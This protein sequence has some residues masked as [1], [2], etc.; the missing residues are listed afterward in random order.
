MKWRATYAGPYLWERKGC[1]GRISKLIISENEQ[2]KKV[3]M[4]AYVTEE[5]KAWLVA[6]A[7]HL[8]F[9]LLFEG[10]TAFSRCRSHVFLL[11]RHLPP[12]LTPPSSLLPPP[13]SL[14]PPL[15]PSLTPPFSS[16]LRT[17]RFSSEMA[18]CDAASSVCL[19]LARGQDQRDRVDEVGVRHGAG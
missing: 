15:R 16:L 2:E 5:H 13:S 10:A 7:R 12:S 4:V 17:D 19:V 18:A 11:R 14:L 6:V 1:S 9:H 8:L 3:A